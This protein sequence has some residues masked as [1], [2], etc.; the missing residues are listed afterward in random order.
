VG[1]YKFDYE[2]KVWGGETLRLS[3]V[4]FRAPRLFYGLRAL[5]SV[6]GRVLDVGC[7]VGDIIE[8][9]SFYRPDLKLY[10]IDIS[11]KAIS[12]AKR[13]VYKA[14][15]CVAD[16]QKIPYDDSFFDAV[17]CFDLIEHVKRP[18]SALS[19]ISRVLKSGGILQIFIPTEGNI[20]TP[21]GLLI[22]LGWKGKQIYGGHPH[23]FT[24]RKAKA[25]LKNADFSI[26]K[27]YWGDH[28]V[29]Q[30]AEISYFSLLLL[31]GRNFPYTIEGY[32]N[33]AKPGLRTSVLAILKDIVASLSF[34]ETMSL[35]W[36]PGLG[37]HLT[38]LKK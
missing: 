21:E 16:V 17:I 5:R 9:L 4:H 3:P 24:T 30:I 22:K 8:A 37:L 31:M 23:C 7:G 11:K 35:F 14:K 28:F 38:C 6:S 15:F 25:M 13:R 33:F 34:I 12:L 36:F 10:G 20:F 29:H 1:G 18:R 27:S 26:I 32:I 2:K 19:E